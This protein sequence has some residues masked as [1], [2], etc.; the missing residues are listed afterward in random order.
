M[1]ALHSFY[2]RKSDV[3]RHRAERHVLHLFHKAADGVVAYRDFLGKNGVDHHKV[4]DWSDFQH[5]PVIDK[6]NYLRQYELK[7][8]C[9]NGSFDKTLVFTSTSG[10]TGEPFYFPRSEELDWQSSIF[11]EAFLR[12]GNT[13]DKGPTL[14]LVAF[15]MGVWIGGLLTYK[16]FEM[17]GHRSAYPISILTPGINKKEIFNALKNVSP[18]YKQ[19]IIVGY[20]PFVKDVLDEASAQGIELEKMNVRFVFAAETFTEG[21]RDY[22]ARKARVDNIYRDVFHVYGSADLGTMAVEM[23]L[24]ILIKRLALKHEHLSIDLFHDISKVPTLAQF[25]PEFTHF[26]AV[27][28]ELVLTG[29]NVLPLIR[30][31]IGDRGGVFDFDFV[32]QKFFD[33]GLDLTEEAKKV[34][35]LD[36]LFQLP[37][38]Y[39]YERVDFATTLYGITIYPQYIKE[40][41][42]DKDFD[43]LLTGKFVLSTEFD[44][45][46][47]QYLKIHLELQKGIDSSCVNDS[48]K[49]KVLEQIIGYLSLKVS[50]F[51]E[52]K[53]HLGE[54]A[55][56]QLKFWEAEHPT[57]FKPGVKQAW[58]K[59]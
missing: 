10:S 42:L 38:V 47:N 33:N 29:N 5:V 31:G 30:Y 23:P 9:W 35:V 14:I 12:Y 18:L 46:H 8:L 50:E 56:P 41:L 7:D 54:R 55:H 20:P 13:K 28:D 51:R 59:K 48:I 4:N 36:C 17:C 57:Y 21:F 32:K 37:F 27:Q 49:H 25:N 52:L 2:H 6:K 11:H 26:D 3:W 34:G 44:E 15:G 19:T 22:L 43:N 40:A 58:V 39:V 24:S 45:M 16:A 1:R 53:S